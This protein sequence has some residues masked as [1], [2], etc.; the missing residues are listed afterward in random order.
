M[1]AS[2]PVTP[3]VDDEDNDLL[4]GQWFLNE[5]YAR[6]SGDVAA[7]REFG[8]FAVLNFPEVAA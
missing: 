3:A 4:V 6:R 1:S 2:G 8:E 5:G 7:L